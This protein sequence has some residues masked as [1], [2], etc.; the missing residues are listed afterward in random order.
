[1]SWW[2][3]TWGGR[4]LSEIYSNIIYCISIDILSPPIILR[5]N[6]NKLAWGLEFHTLF[7]FFIEEQTRNA[8][9]LPIMSIGKSCLTEITCEPDNRLSTS[10]HM[11]Q[12]GYSHGIISNLHLLGLS[13]IYS[14]K[15]TAFTV[16]NIYPNC[17][18]CCIY[19]LH[20]SNL[21]YN[22]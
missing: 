13:S 1:M 2:A 18:K 22:L 19:F 15:N 20:S 11:T 21:I 9:L 4:F 8:L 3:Q 17:I 12:G 7:L 14:F 16:D 10:R 5:K 6:Q